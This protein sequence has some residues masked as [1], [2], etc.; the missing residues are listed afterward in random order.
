VVDAFDFWEKRCSINFLKVTYFLFLVS[1]KS[2]DVEI[3]KLEC[4]DHLEEGK[5]SLSCSYAN[6][7]SSP[8]QNVD[9]QETQIGKPSWIYGP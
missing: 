1:C 8:A 9:V 5:E 4:I 6:D 3:E 2:R 7:D